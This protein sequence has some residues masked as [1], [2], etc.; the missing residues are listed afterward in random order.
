MTVVIVTGRDKNNLAGNVQVNYINDH[1][2]S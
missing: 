2:N 1:Q